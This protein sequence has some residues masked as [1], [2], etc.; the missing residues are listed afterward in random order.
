MTLDFKEHDTFKGKDFGKAVSGRWVQHAGTVSFQF[1]NSKCTYTGGNTESRCI[2]GTM[3]AFS[4]HTE[5]GDFYMIH[6]RHSMHISK[7]SDL[8]KTPIHK[9]AV[10]NLIFS[11]ATNKAK[12]DA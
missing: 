11:E 2:T 7:K 6:D 12:K 9:D 1:D 4:E 8:A 3:A 5:V 10:G